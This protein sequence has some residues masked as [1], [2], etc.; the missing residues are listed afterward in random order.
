MTERDIEAVLL[1][2]GVYVSTT[3]GV[4]MYP[5]LRD[6]RDTVVISRLSERAEKYD[7]LL[8]RRS[9]S[10]VLH[11]VIKVLPDSYVIRGDNCVIREYGI[12]DA[13]ILG[14]LTKFYR[15]NE[16]MDMNGFRYKLY[17]R[18][19]VF[20]HPLVSLKLRVKAKIQRSK[21]GR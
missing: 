15:G 21:G 6:R 5:M 11:R 19:I 1:D 9:G 13:D 8:Y 18:L 12:K 10:Y 4:S 17:S 14:K 20:F 7:V 2:E 3:S 16:E